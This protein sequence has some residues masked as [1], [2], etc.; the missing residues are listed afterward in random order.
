MFERRMHVRAER[1]QGGV[2]REVLHV[3]A[4]LGPLDHGEEFER[5]RKE[6]LNWAQ[7]RTGSALLEA[8]W[9]GQ[10]F[11]HLTGGRTVHG[12]PFE[13]DGEVVWGLRADD[14]DKYVPGRVWTTEATIG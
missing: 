6:I 3:V 10:E 13:P 1:P 11:E 9:K 5:A 7:N 14:P 2:E 4:T 8:A 12:V